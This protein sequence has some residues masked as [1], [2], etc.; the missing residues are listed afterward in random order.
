MVWTGGTRAAKKVKNV[1][2]SLET[3]EVDGVAAVVPLSRAH[4]GLDCSYGGLHQRTAPFGAGL[5]PTRLQA[6]RQRAN[7]RR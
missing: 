1:G 5:H 6:A 4:R 2:T 7:R 3:F